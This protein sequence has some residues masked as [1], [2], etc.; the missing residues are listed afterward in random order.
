MS[1]RNDAHDP[2]RATGVGESAHRTNRSR[3]GTG[4]ISVRNS[5]DLGDVDGEGTG[6]P[7]AHP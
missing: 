6:P 3:A 7:G 2:G 4:P 1:G 5:T